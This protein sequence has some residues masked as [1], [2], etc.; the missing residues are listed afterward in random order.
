[1]PRDRAVIRCLVALLDDPRASEAAREAL[2]RR[3]VEVVLSDDV[4]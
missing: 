1:M 4:R 2:L 3:L